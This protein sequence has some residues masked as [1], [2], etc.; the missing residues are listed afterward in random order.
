MLYCCLFAQGFT[1]NIYGIC[2]FDVA[3]LGHASVPASTHEYKPVVEAGVHINRKRTCTD[4]LVVLLCAFTQ[5]EMGL[6]INAIYRS[7]Q[8][9]KFFA[10]D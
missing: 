2:F 10:W 6:S 3:L 9:K 4:M 8:Q 1:T 7:A 5:K